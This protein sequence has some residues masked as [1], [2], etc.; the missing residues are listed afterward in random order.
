MGKRKSPDFPRNAE[1][2]TGSSTAAPLP[3]VQPCLPPTVPGGPHVGQRWARGAVRCEEPD[4]GPENEVMRG[5]G[6]DGD[7]RSLALPFVEKSLG[8]TDTLDDILLHDS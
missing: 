4:K 6:W 5:M 8:V 3:E 2:L 1:H 7:N